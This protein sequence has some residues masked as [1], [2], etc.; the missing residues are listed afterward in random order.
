MLFTAMLGVVSFAGEQ[1]SASALEIA[2]ANVELANAV[3]LYVAVD[4]SAFD[5]AEG[6]TLKITN[7]VSGKISE[8]SPSKKI[9]APAG[10]VAFRYA[11]MGTT[12]MG[13]ELKIQAYRN[14]VA[15]GE[16]KTY[17]ILEYA[18]KAH[19]RGDAQFVDL[20][21]AMIKYGASQQKISGN[22]GTYNLKD[23]W[24][25]VVASGAVTSKAIVAR[26]SEVTLTAKDAAKSAL[27]TSALDR[28]E[29]NTIVAGEAYQ[30][31]RFLDESIFTDFSFDIGASECA[32]PEGW[33]SEGSA[34]FSFTVKSAEGKSLPSG[35]VI[36]S[37]SAEG[38][39]I[40]LYTV[41]DGSVCLGSELKGLPLGVCSEESYLTFHIVYSSEAGTLSGYSIG[42]EK[43]AE[44]SVALGEGVSLSRLVWEISEDEGIEL[45][46]LVLVKGNIF[47]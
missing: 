1:D 8:L 15:S 37:D 40:S 44:C 24:S 46:R 39:G 38:E 4:Y 9:T 34:T 18:L 29:G 21:D 33:L 5:S 11:D 28:V 25:L 31:Y 43:I 7:T 20:V 23:E 30:G 2:Y 32:L 16:E 10:C 12:N 6:I 19:E 26:G 42:G 36:K 27:Y 13:D 47:E 17:S 45:E 35:P 14:G 41:A 22:Y 3:Y